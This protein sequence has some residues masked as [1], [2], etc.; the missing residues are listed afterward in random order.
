MDEF[1]TWWHN[2]GSGIA[3]INN[4]SHEQHAYRICKLFAEHVE[5]IIE[6]L[7]N[8]TLEEREIRTG[9]YDF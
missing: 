5:Q 2:I 3:P 8:E 7:K 6:D 4:D 9:D 1:E